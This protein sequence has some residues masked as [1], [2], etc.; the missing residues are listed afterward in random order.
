MSYL[1]HTQKRTQA[2]HREVNISRAP[3]HTRIRAAD[4]WCMPQISPDSSR[5]TVKWATKSFSR[6]SHSRGSLNQTPSHQ[7]AVVLSP[8]H[9]AHGMY[10]LAALHRHPSSAH[11]AHTC[12]ASYGKSFI[13]WA[14]IINTS[15]NKFQDQCI[16]HWKGFL[17]RACTP[18]MF[19][20]ISLSQCIHP[21]SSPPPWT[22]VFLVFIP[23]PFA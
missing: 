17:L 2:K 1:L 23:I 8:W 7:S 13:L 20:Q 6:W 11:V 15:M 22:S 9:A 18:W 21:T 5:S 12:Y 16:L 19:D 14:C 10:T 4:W 3:I